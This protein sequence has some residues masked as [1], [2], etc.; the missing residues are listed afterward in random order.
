MPWPSAPDATLGPPDPYVFTLDARYRHSKMGKCRRCGLRTWQTRRVAH[1]SSGGLGPARGSG[2]ESRVLAWLGCHMLANTALSDKWAPDGATVTAI[3]GQIART[4]DDVGAMTS[5]GGY[6]LIQAKGNLGLGETEDCPLAKALRQVIAQYRHR[7]PAD[8]EDGSRLRDVNP[9]LDRLVI[10]T[11]QAAPETVRKGLVTAASALAELPDALP[12]SDVEGDGKVLKARE[13][14]LEHLRREWRADAGQPPTDAELRGVFRVLRVIAI[15]LDEDGSQRGLALQHLE[16]ALDDPTTNNTVWDVLTTQCHKLAEEK[17]WARRD[18]LRE[19]LTA[20]GV[21]FGP[22]PE[23]R[24]DIERLR[25]AN[26]TRITRLN[27]ESTMPAPEGAVTVARDIEPLLTVG[28]G[29]LAL[30]GAAGCGKT[31]SA[32]HAALALVDRGEDVLFLSGDTLAGN[33][34]QAR[35]ELGISADL[36]TV[37][38]GWRGPGRATLFI[39]GLDITRL[40]ESSAWLI[41]LVTG[42]TG[43]RWRVIATARSHSL[44]YGPRWKTAFA[45]TP[46]DPARQD[47]TLSNVRH[48]LLEDFTDGELAPLLAASPL[49]TDLLHNSHPAL[50]ALLRNPF[51]LKVAT[52]LLR[53]HPSA[54]VRSIRTRQQLLKLYWE[55]RINDSPERHARRKVLTTLTTQMIKTRRPRVSDPADYLDTAALAVYDTLVSRDVLREDPPAPWTDIAPAG[56]SHPVL[57]DYAVAVLI[58]SRPDDPQYLRACLDA[59]PDLAV[60]ARPSLDLH[61]AALWHAEPT[62]E[63]FWTLATILDTGERGHALASLAAVSTC[64]HEGIAPGDLD[65]LAASC[66]GSGPLAARTIEARRLVAQ[67]GGVLVA[68]DLPIPRQKAAVPVLTHLAARLAGHAVSADDVSLAHLATVLAHR[69]TMSGAP[70]TGPSL[71]QDRVRIAED[72]MTVALA[73]P[74]GPGRAGVALNAAHL[75]AFALTK[76]P[77]TFSALVDRLCATEVLDLWG[78]E[79]LRRLLGTLPALAAAAPDLATRLATRVWTYETS[80]DQPRP[81]NSS[82]IMS[83]ST[84]VVGNLE[85]ARYTVGLE[86][87][88]TL[89][90]APDW[91]VEYF[92]ELVALQ[93]SA[94]PIQ[95]TEGGRPA[96]RRSQDL[97]SSSG[98]GALADMASALAAHLAAAEPGD[99]TVERLLNRLA[100]DL[101]HPQV[102]NLL[103]TAA[104]GKPETLGRALLPLLM[105]GELLTDAATLPRAATLLTALSPVLSA[106][107]HTHLEEHLRTQLLPD[108]ADVHLGCLRQNRIQTPWATQRLGTL[109][110]QG[111]APPIPEVVR[112]ISGFTRFP[113]NSAL[114]PEHAAV[115]DKPLLI[116]L[117]TL[118]NH[119]QAAQNGGINDPVT[120]TGLRESTTTTL[121]EF[122]ARYPQPPHGTEDTIYQQTVTVLCRAADLLTHDPSVLPGTD[123]GRRILAILLQHAPRVDQKPLG[124]ES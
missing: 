18:R 8:P 71:D 107:E 33:S 9:E 81:M 74:A 54:D 91:A 13:V 86:F 4:I 49:V 88:A 34:A 59:D 80:D 20:A 76:Q 84:T 43:S 75:V 64:L 36:Q 104:A 100:Q 101:T 82:Q 96:V 32:L 70:V 116:A 85:H 63:V 118:T 44:R 19:K 15:D 41:E 22:D 50:A 29:N 27:T 51:N 106:P 105:A 120:A 52:A 113:I 83:F 10:V 6:V 17:H 98:H 61:L 3:G 48:L 35:T 110:Q 99:G 102:W 73:D 56:Y 115:P 90:T 78:T 68:K 12:F 92:L 55:H 25:L 60:I 109:L 26:T 16:K 2:L 1:S 45:G 30:V 31:T 69:I 46:V 122:D 57:F 65:I 95:H 119:V 42:L 123:F 38:L 72:T 39:D 117:D 24:R 37:L 67:L 66:E 111:G 58:L 89:K 97:R 124:P 79:V 53:D 93:A 112:D 77:G 114:N 94:W 23:H 5:A 28:N 14:L 108:T 40:S 47:P 7:V 11:D 87:T 62:R 21:V 103:L 121:H